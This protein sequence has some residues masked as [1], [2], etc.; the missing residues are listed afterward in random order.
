M[1]IIFICSANKDRSATAEEWAMEYY[2]NHQY[3]SVGSNQKICFQL[4]TQYMTEELLEW[5]ERIIVMEKKHK[6]DIQ[7]V[8]GSKFNQKVSVLGIR[9]YY[10]YQEPKLKEIIK[11]KL[12]D[13]L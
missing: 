10:K 1:N 2:P 4:G 6:N 5:A 7:H 11:E 3:Q 12:K 9:D 13:L 8:F